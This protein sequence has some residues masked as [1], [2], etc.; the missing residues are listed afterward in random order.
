MPLRAR[1]PFELARRRSGSEPNESPLNRA[2][3]QTREEAHQPARKGPALVLRTVRGSNVHAWW[4]RV[5]AWWQ[6]ALVEADGEAEPSAS[7]RLSPKNCATRRG[8]QAAL[9][10]SLTSPQ[11][12]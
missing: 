5:R 6:R 1:R 11:R 3:D 2:A 10:L 9:T 12:M 7:C 8:T 4:R